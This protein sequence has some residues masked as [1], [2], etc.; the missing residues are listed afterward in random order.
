MKKELKAFFMI[1]LML[2]T[3]ISAVFNVNAVSNYKVTTEYNEDLKEYKEIK[4][5]NCNCFTHTD[6]LE[7]KYPRICYVLYMY[8]DILVL[9]AQWWNIGRMLLNVVIKLAILFN[10]SL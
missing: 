1:S 10:C 4:S 2:I 3:I 6:L 7:D 5:E 8:Y 9:L